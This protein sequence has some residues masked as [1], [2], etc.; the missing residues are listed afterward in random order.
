[1]P[2]LGRDRPRPSLRGHAGDG[3]RRVRPRRRRDPRH[4]RRR[5][6]RPRLSTLERILGDAHRTLVL[7]IGGG[8]D[9][10][11]ALATARLCQEF[12]AEF[13][14]G[15]VSWERWPI[16]PHPGPRRI[17][18]ILGGRPLSSATVLADER[19]TTPDGTPFGES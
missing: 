4:L 17:D 3:G 19:T 9:V 16:D 2:L 8:G 12:G 18:E 7:G 11:G 15:G 1:M 5:R 14:L 6:A 13:V 10:V